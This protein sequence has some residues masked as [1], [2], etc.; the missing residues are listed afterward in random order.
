MTQLKVEK[1][2]SSILQKENNDKNQEQ[3]D[4]SNVI[5]SSEDSKTMLLD[6]INSDVIDSNEAE[7]KEIDTDEPQP[8]EAGVNAVSLTQKQTVIAIDSDSTSTQE[9]TKEFEGEINVALKD[10]KTTKKNTFEVESNEIK[11]TK[12]L[13]N[14]DTDSGIKEKTSII[15]NDIDKPK[16]INNQKSETNEDEDD[17]Q[18]EEL[19]HEIDEELDHEVNE[20]LDHDI[21]EETNDNDDDD[22]NQTNNTV[23]LNETYLSL[24]F[25]FNYHIFT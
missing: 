19:D 11:Q 16:T 12:C 10:S 17:I 6:T 4:S 25:L 21:D 1:I 2:T 24:M 18:N 15:K 3:V 9:N 20:E 13:D 7:A 23:N 22:L 5:A 8:N 14:L